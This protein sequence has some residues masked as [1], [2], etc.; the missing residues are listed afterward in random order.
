M[1]LWKA[2]IRIFK[3]INDFKVYHFGS[4]V[5]RKFKGNSNIVTESGSRG[6]KIFLLK[7]G[8]SIK[9]FRKYFL[10]SDTKY[11][12]PL[13]K[14]N[15]NFRYFID[16]IIDKLN[17]YYIKYIYNFRNKNN[18]SSNEIIKN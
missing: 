6:A 9:F 1:K 7:W 11:D 12:G 4:I 15:K 10:K 17:F 8:I 5:T 13:V 3:G 16:L 14:Q 2:G 18:L